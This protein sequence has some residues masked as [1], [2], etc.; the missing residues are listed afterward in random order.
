MR[1]LTPHKPPI[2][3]SFWY[4]LIFNTVAYGRANK[5]C[6]FRILV[7]KV[8][9]G[10]LQT[11]KPLPANSI[12]YLS[13]VGCCEIGCCDHKNKFNKSSLSTTTAKTTRFREKL[14]VLRQKSISCFLS[15]K[16]KQ[17]LY[18][19]HTVSG[20]TQASSKMF[21]HLTPFRYL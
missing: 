15:A 13:E 4:F 9:G 16:I 19:G 10:F 6:I 21:K 18:T 1:V 8:I 5:L 20:M 2:N 14:K 11:R 7:I 3:V 12:F 17:Y